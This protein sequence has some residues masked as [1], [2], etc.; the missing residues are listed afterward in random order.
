M[1]RSAALHPILRVAIGLFVFTAGRS[2]VHAADGPDPADLFPASTLAYAELHDPATVGPQLL[3]AVKGSVLE[4]GLGFIHKRR[5][6]TK[7]I[8]DINGKD[9]LALAALLTSPELQAEFKKVR[10]IA[11]G[12][13]GFNSQ[14]QPEFAFIVL[15]GDSNAIGIAVRAYLTLENQVRQVGTIGKDN[16]PIYQYRTPSIN[17][18]DQGQPKLADE[19][20]TEGAHETTLAY[21][22]GVFVVGSSKKAV[23]EVISRFTGETRGSLSSSPAFK[24]AAATYQQPGLF[25][26]ADAANLC[27]QYDAAR[28]TLGGGDSDAIAWFRLVAGAKA[29]QSLAGT[30]RVRDGGLSVSVGATLDPSEKSPLG[31]ALAGNGVK[32]EL[33]HPAQRPAGLAFAVTLPQKNRADAAIG[34]LDALAK[35]DGQLGR[36]PG[37]AVTELEKKYKVPLREGLIG[38]THAVTVIY[39]EKQELP[40]GARA[41]PLLVLHTETEDVGEAWEAFLPML[42]ADWMKAEE[43]PQPAVETISGARVFTLGGPA[44]PWNGPIHYARSGT[45]FVIGADRKLVAA[46]ALADPSASVLGG[47][48]PA[49]MPSRTDDLVLLG[50]ISPG[51]AIKLLAARPAEGE[52]KAIPYNGP[53]T[54]DF[55]PR[56][57]RGGSEDPANADKAG[58]AKAWDAFLAS[59]DA[60]PPATVT[61]RRNGNNLQFEVWQPKTQSGGL[62]PVIDAGMGWYDKQ[63]NRFYDPNGAINGNGGYGGPR[64]FRRFR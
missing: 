52:M 15:T 20:I 2:A 44:L 39:P 3:A 25:F 47:D 54:P 41:I 1:L 35:A 24:L 31:N 16:L 14:G 19:K 46:A 10:G 37:E 18:D 13:I 29:I 40:K 23:G 49:M 58:E 7:D 17:Y 42:V 28:R 21:T 45:R 9:E 50:T 55:G 26:Y 56:A 32:V 57:G 43:L 63:L 22:P 48:R 6:G 64:S 61:V 53:A 8:R 34:F 36:L 11:V 4:D 12:L 60:L 59:F 38:K 62:G 5:N 30:I 27:T 33:L 51:I